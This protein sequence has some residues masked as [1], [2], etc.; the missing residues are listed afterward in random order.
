MWKLVLGIILL[1]IGITNVIFTW[2]MITSS[3]YLAFMTS[4]Y[5]LLG[6][7]LIWSWNRKRKAKAKESN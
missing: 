7:W 2:E 1:L 3:G 4:L 6:V 5:T